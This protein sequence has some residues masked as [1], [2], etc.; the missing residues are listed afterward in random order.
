MY[1]AK[2]SNSYGIGIIIIFLIV[3]I[4]ILINLINRIEKNMFS[5]PKD[6]E[7]TGTDTVLA[8][9]SLQDL[10]KNSS[11]SI[12]RSIEIKSKKYISFCRQF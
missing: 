6:I 12:V 9:F 5:I 3:I 4:F 7:P 2:K 8:E 10:A 1:Y 11:Y